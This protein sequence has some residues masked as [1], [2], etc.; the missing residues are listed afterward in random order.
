MR[1]YSKVSPR[2]WTGETG[3][4]IR[5]AGLETTLVALYLMSC[6]HANMTGIFYVPVM[7]IAHET[8]ISLDDAREALDNLIELGF[9]GYDEEA[10]IVFIINMA[11]FQ[12]AETLHVRDNRRIAVIREVEAC[13]HDEFANL[14]RELYAERYELDAPVYPE[15]P[16]H[17][18]SKA[19][20]DRLMRRDGPLCNGCGA[21]F[22]GDIQPT[23]DHRVAK[24]NG[25]KKEDSNLQLLC[26]SCNC[27]KSAEDRREFWIRA[28]VDIPATQSTAFEG[29]WNGKDTPSEGVTT[30]LDTPSEGVAEGSGMAKKPLRSQEQEQEQEHEQEKQT[31]V[32]DAP[33]AGADVSVAKKPKNLGLRELI[34]LGV[35]RQHAED[36][37]KAR[38]A[39]RLPLTA[40]A[41]D[42]VQREAEKA[43]MTLPEAIAKAAA[44]GWAGFKASWVTQ[45]GGSFG[46]SKS[47]RAEGFETCDYGPGGRL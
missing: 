31:Q 13:G 1:D 8:G 40:T 27:R 36:W 6:P 30:P 4:G 25:G 19:V 44:E 35:D 41:L 11:R 32:A 2:F 10:E 39:K 42:G 23:V 15:V 24:I 26:K 9:C 16:N 14:F 37:L 7:Y 17:R 34:A 43:G 28:G 22:G 3:K 20:V 45:G 38:R 21:P 33:A 5:K 29:V 47:P 12:V 46:A 18:F